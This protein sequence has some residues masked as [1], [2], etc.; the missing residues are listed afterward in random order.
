MAIDTSIAI[1]KIY[2]NDTACEVR[3]VA[4]EEANKWGKSGTSGRFYL[5]G[6]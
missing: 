5:L 3:D 1:S 6:L 2:Y 4:R